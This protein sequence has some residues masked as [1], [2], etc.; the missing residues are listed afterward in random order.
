MACRR[1]RLLSFYVKHPDKS[2][3]YA[4]FGLANTLYMVGLAVILAEV[5][6]LMYTHEKA[7]ISNIVPLLV[8]SSGFVLVSVFSIYEIDKTLKEMEISLKAR[9]FVSYSKASANIDLYYYVLNYGVR[10]SAYNYVSA[11]VMLILR[12]GSFFPTGFKILQYSKIFF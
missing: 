6:L 12:I 8:V 11:K 1:K 5:F 3:G 7:D 9:A 4:F 10:F 2:G